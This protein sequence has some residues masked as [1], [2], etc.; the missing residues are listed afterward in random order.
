MKPFRFQML[1]CVL[2]VESLLTAAVRAAPGENLS[3]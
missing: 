1:G 3:P 2:L